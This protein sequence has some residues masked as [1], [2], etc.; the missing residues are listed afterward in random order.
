M[1]LR[2]RSLATPDPKLHE[3]IASSALVSTVM[4]RRLSFRII[5]SQPFK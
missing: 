2:K 5:V 4:E 3:M 1:A